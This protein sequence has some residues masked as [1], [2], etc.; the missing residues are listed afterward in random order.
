MNKKNDYQV[1][2]ITSE[3]MALENGRF[4]TVAM[5]TCKCKAAPL[6]TVSWSPGTEQDAVDSERGYLCL[7]YWVHQ[8]GFKTNSMFA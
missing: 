1:M 3:D 4:Y 6:L 7:A 2:S 8:S 5:A